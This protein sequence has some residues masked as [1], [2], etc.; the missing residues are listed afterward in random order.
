MKRMLLALVLSVAGLGV[1]AGTSQAQYGSGYNPGCYGGYGYQSYS[2][3]GYG[4]GGYG[5]SNYGYRNYGYAR[6]VIEHYNPGGYVPRGYNGGYP[7]NFH[8]F[9]GPYS[10]NRYR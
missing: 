4:Y 6:P 7:G 10:A 9:S 1:F 3:G 8:N 5:Y 2:Y